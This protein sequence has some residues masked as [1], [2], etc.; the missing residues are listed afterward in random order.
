MSDANV[1]DRQRKDR[2]LYQKGRELN[3]SVSMLGILT[4]I[5]D[6]CS[7]E[8]IIHYS[9]YF[10]PFVNYLFYTYRGAAGHLVEVTEDHVRETVEEEEWPGGDTYDRASQWN[11]RNFSFLLSHIAV[12]TI[13]KQLGQVCICKLNNTF[14]I[15]IPYI[16]F[17]YDLIW[18]AW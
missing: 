1:K 9:T 18:H 2:L 6:C 3:M 11:L 8:I 7:Y 5:Y 14:S 16:Y 10:H 13:T 12:R 17:L 15:Q 4:Q